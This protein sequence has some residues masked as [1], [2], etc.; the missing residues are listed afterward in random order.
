MDEKTD[1]ISWI[2]LILVFLTTVVFSIFNY[3]FQSSCH[4]LALTMLLTSTLICN[5]SEKIEEEDLARIKYPLCIKHNVAS[6]GLQPTLT[7]SSNMTLPDKT[8]E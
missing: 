1:P 3:F 4:L 2:I 8:V 6:Q 5:V 7:T